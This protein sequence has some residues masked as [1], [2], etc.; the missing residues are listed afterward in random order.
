MP[1]NIPYLSLTNDDAC[2]TLQELRRVFTNSAE[3][4]YENTHLF[5]HIDTKTNHTLDAGEKYFQ[6]GD[7][8]SLLRS[9]RNKRLIN[10]LID[11][12]NEELATRGP[13]AFHL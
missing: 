2:R 5:T 4:V 10:L 3:L 8:N 11:A 7:P 9:P 1:R 6:G 12:I 13:R